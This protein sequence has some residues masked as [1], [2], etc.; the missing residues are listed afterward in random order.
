M[1]WTEA[2]NRCE[3]YLVHHSSVAA[4]NFALNAQEK[5]SRRDRRTVTL[6]TMPLLSRYG[7]PLRVG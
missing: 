3:S 4:F 5:L 6:I 1:P 2:P 7:Y